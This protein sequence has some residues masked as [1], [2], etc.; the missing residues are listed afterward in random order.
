MKIEINA[1]VAK[2]NAK[3]VLNTVR[4]QASKKANSLLS[5]FGVV[6]NK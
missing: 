6:I 3:K 2:D 1:N 5:F 4:E